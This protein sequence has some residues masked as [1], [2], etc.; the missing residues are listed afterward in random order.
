MAFESALADGRLRSRRASPV[1]RPTRS[2]ANVRLPPGFKL[3]V[4]TDKVPVARSMALGS[5]GTLFVGT[6][7]G[8]S[9]RSAEDPAAARNPT[10]AECSRAKLNMPNGVAFRDGALYVAEVI[11]SL[12]YDAIESSLDKIARAQG[13]S[14]RLCRAIGH[15]G[16]KYIAFGPDGKLYVPIGAP[17]NVCIEP[18]YAVI[19]RM[20]PDGSGREVFAR[21][22][23]NTVGFTW[24][25]RRRNCGS[26]TT[27]AICLGDD[28]P[29]CELNVAPRTGLDFGFPYCHGATSR[30]PTSANSANAA[31]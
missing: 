30:I 11:A 7:R 26:P 12:R 19:T 1:P 2:L 27:A 4:Y 24:H 25:P 9:M 3:E 28:Q 15:H 16:W 8:E 14:R 29:P 22:I 10:R 31:A 5:K 6:R 18:N 13:R 21:G 20:N 23:R 17:C